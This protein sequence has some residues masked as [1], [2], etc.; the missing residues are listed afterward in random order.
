MLEAVSN[1]AAE[2]VCQPARTRGGR[3]VS[4]CLNEFYN[5]AA[6][7]LGEGHFDLMSHVPRCLVVVVCLARARALAVAILTTQ[8]RSSSRTL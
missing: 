8:R 3:G 6:R 1:G 4:E 5:S 2:Q 7:S